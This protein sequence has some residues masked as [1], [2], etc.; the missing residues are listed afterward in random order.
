MPLPARA[1]GA[2]RPGT[3][4]YV[5][6]PCLRVR[7]VFACL[8]CLFSLLTWVY[9]RGFH[10]RENSRERPCTDATTRQRWRQFH[11]PGNQTPNPRI[12]RFL[13]L[14]TCTLLCFTSACFMMSYFHNMTGLHKCTQTSIRTHRHTY[15][16][17]PPKTRPTTPCTHIDTHTYTPDSALPTDTTPRHWTHR[18]AHTHTQTCNCEF[19]N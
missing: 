8:Q 6:C 12:Y 4:L 17:A 15:E 2:R 7:C 18:H 9:R 1:L 16:D 14:S 19:Q 3:S 13:L 5:P 10:C 11:S